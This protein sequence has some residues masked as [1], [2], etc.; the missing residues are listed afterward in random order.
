MKHDLFFGGIM[1]FI[2]TMMAWSHNGFLAIPLLAT[3][4][5]LVKVT[6]RP[7]QFKI[8]PREKKWR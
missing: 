2:F 6:F 1:L 4:F 8:M 3:F 5:A 7:R